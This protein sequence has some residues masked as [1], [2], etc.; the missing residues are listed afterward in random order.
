MTTWTRARRAVVAAVA[1]AVVAAACGNSGDDAG[2]ASSTTAGGPTTTAAGNDYSENRPV[3]APGVSD[4]EIRVGSVTSK[5][6]PLGGQ[7]AELND[8]IKAYFGLVN[9]QGGIYGRRLKLAKERDD[10]LGNNTQ[11]IEALLAQDNVYAAFIAADLFTGAPKLAEA[12][13]PTFGWN[14]NAEWA[15]PENFYPNIA[16]LCFSGCPL[17]P[18]VLPTVVKSV[19]ARRVA[20]LAYN[21]PQSSDCAKGA[22]DTMKHFGGNVGAE[23]VFSDSSMQFGQ[24]DYSAQV[25]QMKQRRADFL[26]TCTDFNADFAIAKEMKKQGVKATFYHPNMYNAEFVKKNA[27]AFEGDIVLAQITAVEHRP[28]IPAVKEYLD[29]TQANGV[30]V[31]EM[32]MQGWI[33]ARQFVDALKAAGPNFTWAN[34]VAAWNRQTWYTAGGWVPP[35]D[36]SRQH[37]DPGKDPASRSHFECTNLL[38]I[39]SGAFVPYLAEPGKPW[40]CWDFDKFDEWQDPVHVSFDRG[41]FTLADAAR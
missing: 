9:S 7:E 3:D 21:V 27:S 41:P 39:R 31:S 17:L 26:V 28:A 29:Y 1:L 32:T 16:P 24:A 30:K 35:I 22:V 15:G 33:A 10:M 19:N 11:E 37:A 12:G 20:V 5:T 36:W 4:R 14:I 2:K 25:A 13:I 18:H 6:S 34:L 38:Q 8:G 40:L 23:V